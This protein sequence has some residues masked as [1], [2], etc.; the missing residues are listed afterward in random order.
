MIENE[1]LDVARDMA[2]WIR[3]AAFNAYRTYSFIGRSSFYAMIAPEY[4]D[5]MN[6]WVRNWLYWY[7]GYVPYFHSSEQ[8]ILSTRIATT[9]CDKAA[10]K[11]TGG[12]IMYKNAGKDGCSTKLCPALAFI[13]GEWANNCNFGEVVKKAV[14][15]AAAAGTAI[16][17]LNKDEKGLWAEALRFDSFL[18][19]IGARGEIRELKCFLKPFINLGIEKNGTQ[20]VTTF[21][22]VEHRYFGN[23]KSATGEIKTNVPLCEYAVHKFNGTV[24]GG[25]YLSQSTNCER[26][27]VQ[28]LPKEV[29]HA[30]GASYAGI[31]FDKPII[32]PFSDSLGCEII[33]WTD[34]IGNI[35][36]LPFGES[37]LSNTI[38]L[39][40]TWD[41]YFSAFTTD[42]YVG[43]G[44]VLVPSTM[45]SAKNGYNNGLDDFIY[46]K[47][48]YLSPDEQ[49]PF[50]IQFDLRSASW[51]E[52]R[53]ML[54]ENLAV[55]TGLNVS[56]IASFLTD[57]TARTAREISTEE[58]DTAAFVDEKRSLI[59]KPINRILELVT[60]FYG[61]KEKVV[62]RWSGAGLTNRHSLT[63]L[64]NL[65]VQGGFLSKYKAVQLFNFD[66]DDEQV[67]EE[68]ERIKN[69]ENNEESE[70]LPPDNS[71]FDNAQVIN[72]KSG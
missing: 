70:F 21:Y 19:V 61:Y 52:I 24:T 50:P 29:R 5:F 55:Q 31:L 64:I 62:V 44:R 12:R 66:D 10:K 37:M 11:V 9:I 49:K 40:M 72:K 56:T 13:S 15:Y 59:E 34:G 38:A 18:P 22:A 46:T 57:N 68:Y 23:Y 42:M 67:Q 28:D 27:R 8:G 17:K 39:L 48:E 4:F 51:K 3:G 7:D 25:N 53:D 63:E 69:E 33:K 35:P 20:P 14:K 30:L 1:N 54:L 65:A 2:P 6:R 26:I 47:L 32:L 41:Y 16:L 58:N 36:E 45:K 60:R 43:R 71:P